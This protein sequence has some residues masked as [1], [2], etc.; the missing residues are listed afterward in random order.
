[1]KP[2]G[3]ETKG[4]GGSE[5]V[6]RVVVRLVR[7][8]LAAF[9]REL[10]VT[11]T[12]QVPA[13]R[14][15]LMV[16]WHPNAL[17]DPALIIARSPFP[18]MFGARHGLFHVPI[19]GSLLRAVG[20][21]PIYRASD[22]RGL[23][24]ERRRAENQRSLD[25][26]AAR[27]AAGEF[28]ALFPE[29]L[30]HDEPHPV[31]LKTGL[32]RLYYRA[33]ALQASDAPPPAI[34]PVGLHY[35]H[36]RSFR[37]SALVWFHRPLELPP[38]L[39]VRPEPDE[40]IEIA[41]NRWRA[42]TDEIERVL[43]DV[44]H[45]TDDWTIHRI[46]HR[47]RKLLRAE[48]AR[49][50]GRD[51]GPPDVTEKTE[52]FARIRSAYY[53]QLEHNPDRVAKIRTRVERYD[54]DLRALGL[55][56][57]DLD[58][59]PR[60]LT[61]RLVLLALQAVVVFLFV[62]AILIPGF[63]F[64]IPAALMVI[65]IAKLGSGRLSK[66]EASLK[67]LSGAVLF[68]LAWIAAGVIGAV[69]HAQLA[70]VFPAIGGAPVLTGIAVALAGA[71]GGIAAVRYVQVVRETARSIQIRITRTRTKRTLARL[72]RERSGIYD[73]MIALAD[74]AGSST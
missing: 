5:R 17:V 56:D 38:E 57:H 72:R 64:N 33:R 16:S 2:S 66:D 47:G 1:V 15:G 28:S 41:Q 25:A 53:E 46:L 10:D 54:A 39:D 32:A 74:D 43:R 3:D 35:D 7:V 50:E 55:D 68:P 45:A 30:S 36:K 44:V 37:S 63:L 70:Q 60:L 71:L 42:L 48:D 21:V 73:E 52:G 4:G 27:V 18:V 19:L 51:P 61:W 12:D 20:T 24:V 13:D 69:A 11:G 26:L 58:L 23:D 62:P 6:R 8:L 34:V 31:E 29:G 49:R 14:G 40:S 22:T 59:A 67:I 9:F 65:G